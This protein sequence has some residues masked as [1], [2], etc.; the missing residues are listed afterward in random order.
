M[1]KYEIAKIEYKQFQVK[2]KDTDF[3]LLD[4][5]PDIKEL[6][7]Y[8]E[9]KKQ[10]YEENLRTKRTKSLLRDDGGDFGKFD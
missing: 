2:Y 4:F 9:A 8:Q 1:V 5:L 3:S 6:E 7:H 10:K